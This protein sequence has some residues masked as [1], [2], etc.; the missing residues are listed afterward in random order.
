MVV[1][2]ALSI[3]HSSCCIDSGQGL[4]SVARSSGEWLRQCTLHNWSSVAA[5]CSRALTIAL[6]RGGFELPLL[7]QTSS[8]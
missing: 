6:P 1:R 3:C 5:S 7:G 8:K 4:W 2:P